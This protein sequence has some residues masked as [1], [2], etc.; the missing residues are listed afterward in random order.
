MPKPIEIEYNSEMEALEKVLSKVNRPGDFYAAGSLETIMPRLEIQGVGVISFPLPEAQAKEIIRHAEAAPYG[1][2]ELTLVDPAVRK[3]WQLAPGKL[4]LT[5]AAWAQTL[6]TI[7]AQA[8]E[9]LGC[10]KAAVSAEL[11]KLLLYDEGGF[12]VSHRDT[13]KTERMFG[14]LVVVLPSFHSGGELVVRHAGREAVLEL[15]TPEVSQISYAAFY[16]DCEHEI[17]P[18]TQ[19]NRLCLIY[20]LIQRVS[21]KGEP[22]PLTAPQYDKEAAAATALLKDWAA[23]LDAPPKLVYLLEHKYTPAGLSFSGLKNADAALG[24]VLAQAAKPV[25]LAIHLGIVH[26]TESGAAEV[27]YRP[28]YGRSRWRRRYEEEEESDDQDFEI[29]DVAD[30]EAYIDSWTGA[31]GRTVDFGR[32][33]LAEGE[34]LPA[35]A[36]DDEVP[37]EQRVSE[38]TGNEGASFERA[39]HRA[40]LVLWREDRYPEVLLQG[41]VG[42][43]IPY[44]EQRM[45]EWQRLGQ[46]AQWASAGP[47]PAAVARLIVEGWTAG[48]PRAS[49]RAPGTTP[50][51]GEMLDLLLKLGEAPLVERFVREVIAAE[52]DGSENKTLAA[53]AEFLGAEK[54]GGLFGALVGK[55]MRLFHGAG[56]E[57]LCKLVSR[58]GRKPAPEWLAALS[59][60]AAAAVRA[61]P[62]IA[63]PPSPHMDPDWQRR[64]KAKPVDAALVANL[65]GAVRRLNA[66]ALSETAAAAFAARPKVFPPDTVLVPALATLRRKFAEGVAAEPAFARLWQHAAGFLL[67]RSEFPPAE[68]TDWAQAANFEC[69]CADCRELEAFARNPNERIHRFRVRQ[70]R[71][72]HLEG[73]IQRYRLDINCETERTGSPQTLVCTKTRRT[74]ENR[75]K[76][77]ADDI[78]SLNTLSAMKA[79]LP[80]EL[81]G[82]SQRVHE[83]VARAKPR[84]SG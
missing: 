49:W 21:G 54:A 58:Q 13:E 44:L 56:T 67:A 23:N 6:D 79:G 62:E 29:I 61:L 77:Y 82:T 27:S 37:D 34:L 66:A 11:Y 71:R 74:F 5:G 84:I 75:C 50:D 17:R 69:R 59:E 3:V 7:L 25:G 42:A 46:A 72:V 32:I 65:L 2:G 24:K 36:L 53:A 22:K 76:Q 83:A 33:P 43:V 38:A 41:G 55:N 39:Y 51:R 31:E 26:I 15:R 48:A 70:D 8:A 80:P 14:T 4:A 68:P 63:A 10:D 18:I 35:G 60:I 81:Q 19:G 73:T 9:G 1:R 30:A 45:G 40:A 16:A 57:L 20:N 64:Q 52:Y 78:A 47:A 12:F 28:A